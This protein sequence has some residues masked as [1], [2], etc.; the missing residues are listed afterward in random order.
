MFKKGQF[1]FWIEAIGGAPAT[2]LR[3]GALVAMIMSAA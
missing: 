2:N 1:G 3:N